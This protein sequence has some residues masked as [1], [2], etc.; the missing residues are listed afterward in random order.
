MSRADE[1]VRVSL[2][3]ASFGEKEREALSFAGLTASQFRYETGIEAIRL[4][5]AR[6]SAIVLP[7]MGQILWS[8]VFDGV[9]LAMQSMFREPRPAKIIVETYGC[10]SYHAGLLRMGVP[11]PADT[12]VLHG[13]MPCAEMDA[14]GLACGTD[15]RGP[16]IAVTGSK[17]YAMGFGAHYRATP[18]VKL[19]S[20]E[21]GCEIVMEVENLSEA[22]MDLM[23]MCHVNFAFAKDGQIVQSVPFTPEH[24]VT[25]TVIPGHVTPNPDY[26]AL[27]DALAADPA[28]MRRLSEPDRYDPEQVFYIKGLRRGA[29]GL[30]HFLMLR[31]EGDAFAIAW[32]P[33]VMPHTIRWVLANSDQR[34]AAFAMPATCEP[35]GYL[36]EKRKGNVR[37]LAGGATASFVTRIDYVDAKHASAAAKAIEGNE[38]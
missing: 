12:H 21:T 30:V 31:P 19:R 16:W 27:L 23:Y 26:L 2:Q 36:A 38:E 35:E 10:L 22:P 29:D 1:N 6:G 34:V 13:E 18:S 3:R 28:R 5:N 17:E 7:Y 20:G 4:S 25:R 24:V 11:S 8:A 9:E 33:E 37:S 14:A 15:A 32:D